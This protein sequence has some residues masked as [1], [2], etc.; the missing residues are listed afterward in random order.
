MNRKSGVAVSGTSRTCHSA[1][2]AQSQCLMFGPNWTYPHC[3]LNT[4]ILYDTQYNY[5]AKMLRVDMA[6]VRD[7][8][9]IRRH[10]TMLGP[11]LRSKPEGKAFAFFFYIHIHISSRLVEAFIVIM[12]NC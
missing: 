9:L 3:R 2:I 7:D 8:V 5:F 11:L 4:L 6:E 12:K 1:C 10:K